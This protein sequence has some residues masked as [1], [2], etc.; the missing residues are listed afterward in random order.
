MLRMPE[1][2]N[3]TIDLFISIIKLISAVD[4]VRVIEDCQL[5]I[6]GL[7]NMMWEKDQAHGGVRGVDCVQWRYRQGV[8]LEVIQEWS[9][10]FGDLDI[11]F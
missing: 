3:P 11:R 9:L 4:W 6:L 1:E 8:T 10:G 7:V 5:G 2:T